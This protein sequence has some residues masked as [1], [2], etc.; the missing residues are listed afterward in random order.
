MSTEVEERKTLTVEE[1]ARYLG[2]GRSAAYDAI[3]RGD[4]PVLKIGRRF[5]VPAVALE[6]MLTEA[7]PLHDKG[8][9]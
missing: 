4:I 1:A 6:K 8:A 2:I 7:G 5:L 3:N 9:G